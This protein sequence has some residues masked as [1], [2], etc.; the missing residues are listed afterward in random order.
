MIR[1]WLRFCAVVALALGVMPAAPAGAG[2]AMNRAI[3]QMGPWPMLWAADP[4]NRMSDQTAAISLGRGLFFDPRLSLDGTI[5]CASCH[6]PEL[7]WTDGRARARGLADM[8]RNT[9]SLSNVRSRRWF[10]WDGGSDT[11]WGQSL[12]PILDKREMGGSLE[13]TA[14]LI[15]EDPRLHC[16]YRKAFEHAPNGPDEAIVVDVAKALAAFQETLVTG[17][18][19]FDEYRD[20]LIRNDA[21][22]QAAYPEEAKRGAALFVGRAGCVSCHFGPNFSSMEFQDIGIPHFTANGDVDPGRFAGL[23]RLQSTRYGLLGPFN[24]NPLVAKGLLTAQVAPLHRNWGEF[25]VPSLRN[26]TRTAP[27]MHNGSIPT[28]RDVLRH[29]SHLNEER[30]HSGPD[31]VLRPLN[32]TDAEINDLLAFLES[33]TSQD[34]VMVP[35]PEPCR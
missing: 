17:R 20:A 10:G 16:Q 22:A 32:L 2:E 35:R 27:Y 33:L 3:I 19:P 26:V 24:D 29:Y 31:A 18:T 28:L 4:S 21:A 14:T 1:A 12:R 25:R 23:K 13:R 15:R 5:A 8:D 9:I 30:L 7:V 11:L 6:R 34:P